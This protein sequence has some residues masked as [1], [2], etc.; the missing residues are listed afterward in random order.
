M[1]INKWL[2]KHIGKLNNKTAVITGAT[3]GL[4]KELCFALAHLGAN[5]TLACRNENL[6]NNL[7]SEI[8][9]KHPTAKINF[10][11]LDLANMQSI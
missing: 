5:I 8:L 10:V 7:K 4:G 11:S 3:G 9:Q 6:A 2:N 1:N